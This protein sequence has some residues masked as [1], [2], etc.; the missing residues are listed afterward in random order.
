LDQA[1]KQWV[2]DKISS[3]DLIHFKF[4]ELK[5]PTSSGLDSGPL[6][7]TPVEIERFFKDKSV[8]RFMIV[9]K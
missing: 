9:Y 5:R 8:K 1:R 4:L 6:M 7:F 3:K 2:I